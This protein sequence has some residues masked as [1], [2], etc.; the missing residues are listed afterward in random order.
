MKNAFYVVPVGGGDHVFVS[1]VLSE[2][3]EIARYFKR[4]EIV[5]MYGEVWMTAEENVPYASD[6]APSKHENLQSM[7]QLPL[8][9]TDQSRSN[10]NM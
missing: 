2:C 6:R 3:S 10:T 7:R 4:V 8:K 9:W 5:D 1:N